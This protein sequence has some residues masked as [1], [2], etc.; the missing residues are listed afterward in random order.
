MKCSCCR[1][2]LSLGIDCQ[3]QV[4]RYF[5]LCCTWRNS[6]YIY[7]THILCPDVRDRSTA[8]S[9]ATYTTEGQT[10]EQQ[11]EYVGREK[12]DRGSSSYF[13]TWKKLLFCDNTWDVWK[14]KSTQHTCFMTRE[15]GEKGQGRKRRLKPVKYCTKSRKHLTRPP[16]QGSWH[17]HVVLSMIRTQKPVPDYGEKSE[18]GHWSARPISF[19][20]TSLTRNDEITNGH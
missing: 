20:Q 18:S 11:H 14:L 19:L 3:T 9:E 7:C 6:R 2:I 5:S 15:K 8:A 10:C 4:A 16:N 1:I 12:D 13:F 17:W